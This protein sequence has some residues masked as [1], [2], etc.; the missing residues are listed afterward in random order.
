MIVKTRIMGISCFVFRF[1]G[2]ISRF[3]S[4]TKINPLSIL[5]VFQQGNS[6]STFTKDSIDFSVRFINSNSLL[7]HPKIFECFSDCFLFF[8]RTLGLPGI[9]RFRQIVILANF[10]PTFPLNL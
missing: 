3:L 2:E 4:Q 1:I 5:C 8:Q 6:K 7:D 9:F 10:N